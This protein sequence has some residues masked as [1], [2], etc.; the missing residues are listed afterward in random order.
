[1]GSE[2]P[3]RRREIWANVKMYSVLVVILAAMVGAVLACIHFWPSPH[4]HPAA[5]DV[6]D[7]TERIDQDA[8]R[9]RLAQL[10]FHKPVRLV[11]RTVRG[12]GA[13]DAQDVSDA[14]RTWV[15]SARPDLM[16]PN[17]KGLAKDVLVVTVS[18]DDF[19][20]GKAVVS[21]D[22]GRALSAFNTRNKNHGEN[23]DVGR[24]NRRA[25]EF[26]TKGDWIGGIAHAAESPAQRWLE[27]QVS[28]GL[29]STIITIAGVIGI[30]DLVLLGYAL[31]PDRK[32]EVDPGA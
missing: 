5:V 23:D 1:M 8:L 21:P 4:R 7:A 2:S 14:T 6:Y 18:V 9:G 31:V 29:L 15:K 19:A 11:V 30:L 26:F 13:E 17:G 28:T 20:R 27:P 12:D 16:E 22:L 24:I 32:R 25:N 10:K 3:S